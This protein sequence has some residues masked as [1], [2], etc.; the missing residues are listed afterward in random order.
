MSL[1]WTMFMSYQGSLRRD[2]PHPRRNFAAK[3]EWGGVSPAEVAIQE[4]VG[5]ATRS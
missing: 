5:Y 1:G 2:S 4:G 3:T